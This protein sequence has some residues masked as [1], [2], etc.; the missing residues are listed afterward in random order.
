MRRIQPSERTHREW[1]SLALQAWEDIVHDY[2]KRTLSRRE[3]TLPAISGIAR[4]LSGFIATPGDDSMP[5]YLAGHWW[6]S[7]FH[8]ALSFLWEAP[9]SRSR[10][11]A[12]E[13]K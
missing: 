11:P 12:A 5:K 7:T 2:L 10:V 6:S 1:Q 8:F 9:W 4:E 13:D 3:D